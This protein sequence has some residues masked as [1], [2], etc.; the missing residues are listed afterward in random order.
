M[1]LTDAVSVCGRV[2]SLY[3]EESRG[4]SWS[5]NEASQ[6]QL[7]RKINQTTAAGAPSYVIWFRGLAGKVEP[8]TEKQ[9]RKKNPRRRKKNQNQ[10]QKKQKESKCSVMKRG[11]CRLSKEKTRISSRWIH[12]NKRLVDT[13]RSWLGGSNPGLSCLKVS[14][15]CFQSCSKEEK[16]RAWYYNDSNQTKQEFNTSQYWQCRQRTS[17]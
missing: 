7:N 8:F 2:C 4:L 11:S 5:F 6:T 14:W 13:D 12:G 1:R 3:E 15:S 9:R 16:R 10:N 17:R